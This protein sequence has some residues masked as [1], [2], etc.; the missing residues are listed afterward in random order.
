MA[1]FE[2]LI[3]LSWFVFIAVWLVFAFGAKRKL[4]S[5]GLAWLWSRIVLVL[6]VIVLLKIPGVS[7]WLTS[8]LKHQ[9]AS[10]SRLQAV[11][12]VITVLGITFAIW[13]RLYLGSNW[14]MPMSLREG[15]ELVTSGPYAY[16]RHPIYTGVIT[17]MVGSALA[18]VFWIVALVSASAYF[19][20]SATNE[21]KTMIE[22]F[23]NEYPAYK[24]RTKM[25]VPFIF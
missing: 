1:D 5:G 9:A 10:G 14:G 7:E 6:A 23:P 3:G 22:Q 13:A 16:V 25:L 19:V 4:R 24:A 20:Y 18:N 11:G 17:A 15:H 2:I 8:T 21:E 12:F